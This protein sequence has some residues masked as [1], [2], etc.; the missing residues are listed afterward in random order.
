MLYNMFLPICALESYCTFF[1]AY[2]HK[3]DTHCACHSISHHN[4]IARSGSIRCR[5]GAI[6][7]D[8]QRLLFSRSLSPDQMVSGLRWKTA[9]ISPPILNPQRSHTS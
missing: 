6:Y 8:F 3:N 7:I 2:K 9:A 5:N 4:T 1:R